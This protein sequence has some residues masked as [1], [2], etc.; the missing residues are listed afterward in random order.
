M[1]QIL[2]TASKKPNGKRRVFIDA[3]S[4]NQESK[5]GLWTNGAAAKKLA[6]RAGFEKEPGTT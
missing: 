5:S 2:T 3:L 6:K 1:G 4:K